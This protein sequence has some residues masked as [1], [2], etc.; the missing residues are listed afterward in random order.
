MIPQS[1]FGYWLSRNLVWIILII[2]AG[3][4]LLIVKKSL[5]R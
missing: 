1:D 5:K 2:I 4:V 3:A